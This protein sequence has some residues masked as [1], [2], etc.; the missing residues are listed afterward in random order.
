MLA[1]GNGVRS[2]R[3]DRRRNEKTWSKP[4][5]LISSTFNPALHY[6]P[7]VYRAI[8][9]YCLLGRDSSIRLISKPGI[10]P[11][12]VFRMGIYLAQAAFLFI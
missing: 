11:S 10:H 12:H 8:R 2:Q 4:P 9:C 1:A 7:A 3:N 5:T 6:S